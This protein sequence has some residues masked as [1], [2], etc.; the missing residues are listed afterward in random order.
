MGKPAKRFFEK[1]KKR[2][3]TS[4]AN[5]ASKDFDSNGHSI[6]P[7][8]LFNKENQS[9]QFSGALSQA[10][11][12]N[13][14]G[15]FL[16]SITSGLG[17]FGK[18]K[19]PI[20][21]IKGG[22][23]LV[24]GF[25]DMLANTDPSGIYSGKLGNIS[26]GLGKANKIYSYATGDVSAKDL[27]QDGASIGS[28]IAAKFGADK[29]ASVLSGAALPIELGFLVFQMFENFFGA[30]ESAKAEARYR[31]FR[32]GFAKGLATSILNANPKK[33]V[34]NHKGGGRSIPDKVRDAGIGSNNQ[35][36]SNG[37]NFGNSLPSKFSEFIKSNAEESIPKGGNPVFE[38][39]KEDTKSL[40][41]MNG[42][43]ISVPILARHLL[44]MVDSLFEQWNKEK[45]QEEAKRKQAKI[46]EN[47]EKWSTIAHP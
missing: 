45:K 5:G 27:I 37:Y 2:K 38:R 16:K 15:G 35:G 42:N 19:K 43:K 40:Y 6:S 23:G 17:M 14:T 21:Y 22:S 47:Y 29:L 44:P 36:V 8:S 18:N 12:L 1:E 13:S 30:L 4:K 24:G 31:N 34:Y 32:W 28:K 3:K 20:D 11:S 39:E 26:K 41:Q 33:E 9:D 46:Q 10:D 25:S 7:P